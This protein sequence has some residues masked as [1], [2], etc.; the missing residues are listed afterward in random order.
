MRRVVI[1]KLAPEEQ[2]YASDVDN[3]T[4]YLMAISSNAI[5]MSKNTQ[6]SHKKRSYREGEGNKENFT[7]TP[8]CG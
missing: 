1:L 3:P 2:A 8:L 7:F 6:H 4:L 5:K